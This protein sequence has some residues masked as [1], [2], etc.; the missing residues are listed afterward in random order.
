MT[1]DVATIVKLRVP[2]IVRIARV[3]R[4]VEDVLALG[5][6]AILELDKPAD[7]HLDV[8]VNNKAIGAGSAVKIGESFGIRIEH[9]ATRRQRIEALAGS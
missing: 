5:P 7:D 8:L 3:R 4:P 6:G 9:L 1:T 2:L